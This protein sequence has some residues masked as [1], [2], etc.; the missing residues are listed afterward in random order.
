MR[1]QN[2]WTHGNC[3]FIMPE[4]TDGMKGRQ[5]VSM[6]NAIFDPAIG[7]EV[8]ALYMEFAGLRAGFWTCR[9]I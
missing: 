1:K 2:A 3:N 6:H 5:G 4:L 8:Y 7:D 9:A